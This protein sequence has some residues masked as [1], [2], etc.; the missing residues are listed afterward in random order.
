MG[1][2]ME[3]II[4]VGIQAAGKTT[5]YREHFFNTHIRI[6]LDML[7]TRYREDILVQA[8]ITA[9]QPFVVDNTNVLAAERA[10]Y[11]TMAKAAQ[12]RVVG[13]YFQSDPREALRRNR[14]RTGKSAIPVQGIFGTYKRLEPPQRQEGFDLLYYV[15]INAGNEFVV[16]EW[17]NE[18]GLSLHYQPR[19][20]E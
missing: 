3:A 19:S 4:F 6:N 20:H 10:K 14:Q 13:Y 5:F 17:D 1:Q 9:K 11:I 8:C 16:K 15:Y 18:T 2:S 7:K 12:F